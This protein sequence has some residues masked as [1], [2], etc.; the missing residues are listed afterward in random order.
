MIAARD[1]AQAE[2]RAAAAA[3][4]MTLD[5][6]DINVHVDMPGPAPALALRDALAPAPALNVA[7]RR[8]LNLPPLDDVVYPD[9]IGFQRH[10]RVP[11]WHGMLAPLA[12]VPALD[13]PADL[14]DHVQVHA[15]ALHNAG[16]HALMRHARPAAP[17]APQ[18][19]PPG[20]L[21]PNAANAFGLM[22]A[23]QLRPR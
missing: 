1:A 7:G 22:P 13:G 3:E 23:Q 11:D 21:Q 17:I 19:L 10:F 8:A 12:P 2:V 9:F 4:G 16:H 14:A 20:P 15:Q 6:S 18:P 5:D